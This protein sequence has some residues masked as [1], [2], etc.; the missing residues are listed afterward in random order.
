[1]IT[2]EDIN[3]FLKG[4]TPFY[5]GLEKLYAPPFGS[6]VEDYAQCRVLCSDDP[7]ANAPLIRGCEECVGK[8][9]WAAINRLF[10]DMAG[11]VTVGGVAF[12]LTTELI[13]KK[14]IEWAE[15]KGLTWLTGSFVP[16][17]GWFFLIGEA[18][19]FIAMLWAIIKVYNTSEAAKLKFCKCPN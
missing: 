4:I 15:K 7:F 12:S 5:G 13:K 2:W 10:G 1:M 9:A 16:G 8:I 14:I 3:N 19:N 6:D 17:L 11:E 18:F